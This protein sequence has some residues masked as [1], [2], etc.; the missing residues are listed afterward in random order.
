MWQHKSW[1]V[2]LTEK[3]VGRYYNDNGSLSYL[4]NGF[5]IPYPVDQAITINPFNLVNAFVNYTVKNAN[6]FRGTK[7]QFAMNN[8]A[9]SHSLVGVT[10]ATAATATT[11]F[12]ASGVD[13]L[14]LLPGRKLLHHD[15]RGYAPKR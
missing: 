9:N 8:L 11:P 13:Q 12:V 15:N 10:P 2:G 7:I 6:H 3:R 4:I 14:N 1:D 5:K